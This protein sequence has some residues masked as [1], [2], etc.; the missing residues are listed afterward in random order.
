MVR[1]A[2]VEL[3]QIEAQRMLFNHYDSPNF[4]R[5]AILGRLDPFE[6]TNHFLQSL[7]RG[8]AIG[9]VMYLYQ[10]ATCCAVISVPPDQMASSTSVTVWLV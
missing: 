3:L 9:L 5:I 2:A 1:E 4:F 7:L 6:R 8:S 10:S